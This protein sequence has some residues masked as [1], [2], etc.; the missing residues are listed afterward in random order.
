MC[1][2]FE[3]GHIY[4][5]RNRYDMFFRGYVDCF[6]HNTSCYYCT[7]NKNRSSDVTLADFWHYELLDKALNDEKGLALVTCN[8]VRGVDFINNALT[9]GFRS[10]EVPLNVA[11]IGSDEGEQVRLNALGNREKFTCVAR[12]ESILKAF[13]QMIGVSRA[14]MIAHKLRRIGYHGLFAR[15]R[16][17]IGV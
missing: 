10:I 3:S 5:Q 13:K 6:Y 9:G 12:D 1:I 14:G 17:K 15:I 4:S 8:S 7:H 11:M 16:R 2:K